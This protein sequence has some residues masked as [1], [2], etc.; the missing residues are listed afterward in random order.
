[1]DALLL[2]VVVLAQLVV[3]PLEA[4]GVAG[5]HVIVVDV[6]RLGDNAEEGAQ[7]RSSGGQVGCCVLA[8]WQ[9][10]AVRV[11]VICLPSAVGAAPHKGGEAVVLGEVNFY[12]LNPDVEQEV[13]D[14]FFW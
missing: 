13:C 5:D 14:A 11:G 7:L 2:D 6:A 3:D 1:M 10:D 4:G 9:G 12:L 8:R